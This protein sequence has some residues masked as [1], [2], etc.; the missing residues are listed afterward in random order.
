MNLILARMRTLAVL[1]KPLIASLSSSNM[2]GERLAAIAA[3]Q[4]S[5][6]TI[7]YAGWLAERMTAN[8]PSFSFVRPSP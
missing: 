6:L 1:I 2:A 4:S 5:S 3:L 8:N 7:K